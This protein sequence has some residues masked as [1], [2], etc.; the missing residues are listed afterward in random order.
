MGKKDKPETIKETFISNVHQQIDKSV[1]NLDFDVLNKIA[2]R[3]LNAKRIIIIGIG[4]AAGVGYIL[5]D[6]LSGLRDIQ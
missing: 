5:N 2:K 4:G 6:S 3:V 1:V